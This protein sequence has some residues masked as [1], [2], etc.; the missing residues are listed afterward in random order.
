MSSNG[1]ELLLHTQYD[2]LQIA[3]QQFHH[4]RY[5]DVDPNSCFLVAS[6][7]YSLNKGQATPIPVHIANSKGEDVVFQWPT[8]LQLEGS[9]KLSLE[10]NISIEN[11]HAMFD[12]EVS[13]FMVS[14]VESDIQIPQG[15]VLGKLAQM[16][17]QYL[18]EKLEA[19]CVDQN[20]PMILYVIEQMQKNPTSTIT[21][22]VLKPWDHKETD[23]F[24]PAPKG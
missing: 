15:F 5:E 8:L 10:H 4:E 14:S 2:G 7:D 22:P 20:N 16:R 21:I 1:S 13:T 23:P 6:C 9:V 19:D 18:F 12:E 17:E 11:E 3:Q 24:T